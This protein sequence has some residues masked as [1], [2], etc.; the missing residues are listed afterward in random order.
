MIVA[1]AAVVAVPVV[2]AVVWSTSGSTDLPPV[3]QGHTV[4]VN[5]KLLGQAKPSAACPQGTQQGAGGSGRTILTIAR[6]KGTCLVIDSE[7]VATG[8]VDTRLGALR[9]TADVVAADRKPTLA[10]HPRPW[11]CHLPAAP[12][13]YGEPD[14][15]DQWADKMLNGPDVRKL[16]P[17]GA[18]PVQVGVVDTGID[19]A[20]T[21]LEKV[22]ARPWPT[23]IFKG[24]YDNHGTH[25]AGIIAAKDDKQGVVGLT[26]KAQ[27]IDAQY[28]GGDSTH[29]HGIAASIVAAVNLGADVINMSLGG[30]EPSDTD[31]AAVLYAERQQVVLVASAGNCGKAGGGTFEGKPICPQANQVDYPAAY[32]NVLS[33]ANF[34]KKLRRSSS[35]S[36]NW[37]VDV[38]APG[39]EI[40]S[41][42]LTREDGPRARCENS[43]TSM[44]APFVAATAAL[45]RARHPQASAAAIRRA[46]TESAVTPKDVPEGQ[47][48]D[49]FGWGLLKPTAASSFLDSHPDVP[50]DDPLAQ[51]VAGYVTRPDGNGDGAIELATAAGQRIPVGTTAEPATAVTAFSADGTNFAT[52]NGKTLSIVKTG[53]F[54]PAQVDCA[55]TGAA[56]T[57]Q[58]QV[59]TGDA[60]QKLGYYDSTG[61]SVRTV[62]LTGVDPRMT[63]IR[64]V[65][66]HDDRVIIAAALETIPTQQENLY[67]VDKSGAAVRLATSTGAAPFSQVVLDR[68]GTRL[69]FA[70]QNGCYPAAKIGFAQLPE[71]GSPS[72]RLI[73]SP[74]GSD[75]GVATSLAFD[76]VALVAG[77]RGGPDACPNDKNTAQPA[78]W[79]LANPA[80]GRTWTKQADGR[81]M[82]AKTQFGVDIYTEPYPDHPETFT[83]KLQGLPS[84]FNQ[85]AQLGDNIWSVTPRPLG[86]PFVASY[87]STGKGQ[88]NTE[89]RL[90]REDGTSVPVQ[91]I[92]GRPLDDDPSMTFSPDGTWFASADEHSLT[93]VNTQTGVQRTVSCS[94][95]G[96]AFTAKNLVMTQVGPLMTIVVAGYD[97]QTLT[98]KTRIQGPT[99][100]YK[101]GGGRV[102]AQAGD[103]TIVQKGRGGQSMLAL[104]PR[105]SAIDL[106]DAAG[107]MLGHVAVSADGNF[108]V[109][110]GVADCLDGVGLR[111]VDLKRT[112]ATGKAALKQLYM[113]AVVNG[114]CLATSLHFEGDVLYGGWM[115]VTDGIRDSCSYSDEI[116]GVVPSS[117]KRQLQPFTDDKPLDFAGWQSVSCSRVGQWAPADGGVVY[118]TAGEQKPTL[119]REPI[120]YSLYRIAPGS[121]KPVLLAG[122]I[123]AAEVRMR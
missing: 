42:C 13:Q 36:A 59:V 28:W 39:E 33:V 43:G 114:T 92:V 8:Q 118:L 73:D 68:S 82:V 11:Y 65:A 69:A 18:A 44:A 12:C 3:P 17:Q 46:I 67:V 21:D 104:D 94:C 15:G 38:A 109:T 111:V 80:T 108:L 25:V 26:P 40:W 70:L 90:A 20:N 35:S 58:G 41:T 48:T 34:D 4:R 47:R 78:L 54:A 101:I 100:T 117:W 98:V 24:D 37:T 107:P 9:K 103:H 61:S 51:V 1:G 5:E 122:H 84:Y 16:W 95:K 50:V 89:V 123:A 113:N 64:V 53:S 27:L 91:Q 45:L 30:P 86:S 22:V 60:Q 71:S 121:S 76:N 85:P 115:A 23:T 105:G 88:R 83:L 56:F 62:T 52:A 75:G 19:D 79:R 10:P 110:S 102:V 96:T 2:V 32:P 97:P 57:G 106:I 66:A 7:V 99:D 29:D 14:Q 77:W 120:D 93:T 119:T 6:M 49:A 63:K 112:F 116:E 81:G 72:V 87:L 74:S 55:C 31:L